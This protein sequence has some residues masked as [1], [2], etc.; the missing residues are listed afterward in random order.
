MPRTAVVFTAHAYVAGS[1]N[2]GCEDA[3]EHAPCVECAAGRDSYIHS[4]EGALSGAMLT[5]VTADTGIGAE[6]TG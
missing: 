5:V 3:A 1:P 2:C 6:S 4:E